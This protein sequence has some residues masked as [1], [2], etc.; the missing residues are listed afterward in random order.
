MIAS[1]GYFDSLFLRLKMS[2]SS[3]AAMAGTGENSSLTNSVSS[4]EV[5][6]QNEI[7]IDSE[8][9]DSDVEIDGDDNHDDGSEADSVDFSPLA[10]GTDSSRMFPIF[11]FFFFWNF[12]CE[13]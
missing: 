8:K 12:A 4:G 2:P 3:K 5:S 1:F 13:F 10:S 9:G 6:V 7:G 11:C